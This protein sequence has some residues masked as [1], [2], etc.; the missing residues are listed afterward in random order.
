LQ[1]ITN[2]PLSHICHSTTTKQYQDVPHFY[3]SCQKTN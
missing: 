2:L 3:E 1:I